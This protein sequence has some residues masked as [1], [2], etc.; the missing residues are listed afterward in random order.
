MTTAAPA[1]SLLTRKAEIS[2]RASKIGNLKFQRKTRLR[3]PEPCEAAVSADKGKVWIFEHT[4]EH[5]D[6]SAHDGEQADVGRF[7]GGAEP[8]I[9]RREDGILLGGADGGHVQDVA[10]LDA[11]APSMARL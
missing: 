11:A 4:V 9:E 10:D 1:A 2:N 6:E 7:A 3:H 8:R 5:D